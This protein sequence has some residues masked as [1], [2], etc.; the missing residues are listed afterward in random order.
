MSTLSKESL[1]LDAAYDVI[2]KAVNQVKIGDVDALEAKLTFNL[3]KKQLDWAEKQIKDAV[4]ASAELNNLNKEPHIIGNYKLSMR[5]G[6]GRWSFEHIAEWNKLIERKKNIE[7][8]HKHAYRNHMKGIAAVDEE[9]G[10][11]I[12]P[13]VFKHNGP[14]IVI[15]KN[16][17]N[18]GS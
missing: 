18:E 14:S 15:L 9:T 16:K 6:G 10:E 5:E 13:A 2:Q 12:E 1:K 8:R 4:I 3:L 7:D 17:S 11:I